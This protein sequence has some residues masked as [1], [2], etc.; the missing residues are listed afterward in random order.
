[1]MNQRSKTGKHWTTQRIVIAWYT[2]F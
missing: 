1:M 2:R